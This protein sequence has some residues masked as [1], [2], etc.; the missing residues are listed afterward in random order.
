MVCWAW[1][2]K[3]SWTPIVPAD[4]VSWRLCQK[5]AVASC[6]AAFWV[7]FW[8]QLSRRTAVL[9]RVVAGRDHPLRRAVAGVPAARVEHVA[10]VEVLVEVGQTSMPASRNARIW[11]VSLAR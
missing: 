10:G 8:P 11:S 5:S 1:F 6:T 7:M 9:L 2:R 3:A 4:V